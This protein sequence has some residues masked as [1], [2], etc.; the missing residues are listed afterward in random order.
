MAAAS[1]S[2]CCLRISCA[3]ICTALGLVAVGG[4][5]RCL[6]CSS[7]L[8]VS[9]AS[10]CFLFFILQHRTNERTNESPCTPQ[11]TH[12]C[13]RISSRKKGSIPDIEEMCLSLLA[14]LGDA[15]DSSDGLLVLFAIVLERAVALLLELERSVLHGSR[16]LGVSAII[17]LLG[18]EAGWGARFARTKQPASQRHTSTSSLPAVLLKALVHRTLRGLRFILK[19]LWHLL[20]QNRKTYERAS[21][22][23]CTHALLQMSNTRSARWSQIDR[24]RKRSSITR[25]TYRGVIAHERNSVARVDRST[26]EPTL[27]DSHHSSPASLTEEGVRHA[28]SQARCRCCVLLLLREREEKR[29]RDRAIERE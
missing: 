12:V 16:A 20:R 4:W 11:A 27:E 24:C 19:L 21:P 2:C 6:K 3:R 13:V 10:C 8:R 1:S 25:R 23:R 7:S 29:S 14:D 9:L 5:R 15:L 28:G 26:A 17:Q 22:D 18:G